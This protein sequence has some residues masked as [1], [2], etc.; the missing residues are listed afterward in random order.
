MWEEYYKSDDGERIVHI[1]TEENKSI[2][3]MP[4]EIRLI[5]HQSTADMLLHAE[6]FK[7]AS[8]LYKDI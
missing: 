3:Q 4:F 7:L 2:C 8:N 6:A 1:K 5:E